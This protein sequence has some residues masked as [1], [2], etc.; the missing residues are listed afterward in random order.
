MPEG[1]LV[2]NETGAAIVLLCDGRRC[3]SDIIATLNEQYNR[4]VDLDVLTFLQRL[5]NKRVL[6]ITDEQGE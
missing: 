3:V 6:D 1:V 2:L 4:A 5:A